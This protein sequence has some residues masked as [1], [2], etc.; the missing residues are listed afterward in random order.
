MS[1]VGK[2]PIQIP[3]GVTVKVA[4]EIALYFVE[5]EARRFAE[6][7]KR[8]KLKV[9]LK[10]IVASDIDVPSAL[11]SHA[12]STWCW[13]TQPADYTPRRI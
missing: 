2:K 8:F 7:E 12:A 9:D 11:L 13:S 5:Q 6:L 1:R 4:P 3:K 10:R